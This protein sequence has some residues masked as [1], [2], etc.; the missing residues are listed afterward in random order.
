LHVA[1]EAGVSFG[2]VSRVLNEDVYLAADVHPALTTLRQP[3]EKMGRVASQMLL[4]IL[5]NPGARIDRVEHPA[6]LIIRASCGP[7]KQ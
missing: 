6:E 4:K 3:L 7:V 1:K 5:R 2:I